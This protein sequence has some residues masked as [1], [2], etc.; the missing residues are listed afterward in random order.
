MTLGIPLTPSLGRG[1]GASGPW[2]GPETLSGPSLPPVP[3]GTQKQAFWAR[4]CGLNAILL[5]CVNI[6]FYAYFA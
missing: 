5:M 1:F 3:G 4:V 6:F 2:G